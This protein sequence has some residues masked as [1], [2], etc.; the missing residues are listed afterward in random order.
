METNEKAVMHRSSGAAYLLDNSGREAP[1]RFD[2]LSAIYDHDSICHL[3]NRGVSEGWQCL[4]VGGGGGSITAWLKDRVGS[5]GH[6]LVTDI[7]PRFLESLSAKNV[8]VRRHNIVTDG[9]PE[10]AFDLIHARL[11]LIHVPEREQVLARLVAALKPGGWLV[12][13]DF[14][15][16]SLLPDS[17]VNPG[18]VFLETQKAVMR[19]LQDHGVERRWGRLLFGKMRALGLVNVNA[20]AR[21]SMWHCGSPGALLMRANFE[22]LRGALLER[23]HVTEQQ[24]DGDLAR[25]DDPDFMTP[26]PIMWTAWGRRPSA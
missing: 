3:Q 24:F 6:V 8:E 15:S 9:L 18:E 13:E 14:D 20:V 5:T 16:V 10:A 25:L 1:A 21:M 19:V 7:D 22:Q 4:E 26:S 2:A 11:V 23:H 17:T 12:D